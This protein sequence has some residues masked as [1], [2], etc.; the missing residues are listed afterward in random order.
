MATSFPCGFQQQPPPQTLLFLRCLS[1]S[2]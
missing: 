2:T 1:S